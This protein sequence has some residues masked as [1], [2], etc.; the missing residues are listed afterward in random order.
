[1][2]RRFATMLLHS[3]Y[4]LLDLYE[5]EKKFRLATFFRFFFRDI[6]HHC[7]NRWMQWLEDNVRL[8]GGY[9]LAKASCDSKRLLILAACNCRDKCITSLRLFA[10]LERRRSG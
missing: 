6:C 3:L 4:L 10:S 1:M 5:A 9:P 7:L 2:G 8:V